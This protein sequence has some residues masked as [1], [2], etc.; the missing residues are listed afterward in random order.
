MK[1]ITII[2]CVFLLIAFLVDAAFVVAG[3]IKRNEG[4]H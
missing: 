1:A 3:L 4:L 2:I